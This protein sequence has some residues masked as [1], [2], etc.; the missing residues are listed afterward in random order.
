VHNQNDPQHLSTEER[1]V[2]TLDQQAQILKQLAAAPD[3]ER[4]LWVHN[5]AGHMSA[6]Q[7]PS[8]SQP[9]AMQAPNANQHASDVSKPDAMQVSNASQDGYA[10]PNCG[11][12]LTKGA[13]GAAR[14][15]GYCKQC[16]P[17]AQLD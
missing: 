3:A 8:T 12:T 11:A 9:D 6:M 14:R 7:A 10:C 4:M 13:F 15:F 1:I 2:I 16:K 5:T 17:N